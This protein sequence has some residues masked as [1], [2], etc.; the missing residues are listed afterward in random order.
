MRRP[1]I[2]GEKEYSTKK[3]AKDYYSQILNSYN[4]G[5]SLSNEHYND[6]MALIDH[7]A[8]YY[9]D[10]EFE[11]DNVVEIED[12]ENILKLDVLNDNS[13]NSFDNSDNSTVSDIRIGR[14]QYNTKCFEV[15]YSDGDT[16]VISYKSFI[17]KTNTSS[18]SLFN[19][20]C[21]YTIQ[22]DLI[23]VKQEYFKKYAK[24]SKAPCQESK[25]LLK[26][27]DLVVDHRQPNTLSVIIDRFIEL[28]KIDVDNIEYDFYSFKL[29]A[30]K[31]LKLSS[32]FRSYH[33][34]KALLRVVD[35][36]LNLSRTGMARLKEMKDD[37]KIENKLS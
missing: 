6:L 8:D 24:N 10:N 26:Y 18:L 34:E 13:D 37:I 9:Y 20:V 15:V 27:K 35:K 4:F 33:Q 16:W 29:P 32:K 5:E 1:L 21:R 14:F 19:K 22:P 7:Y 36:R 28:Y 17:D 11:E 12:S 31:D 3:E 30:F 2:I 25:E 23:K